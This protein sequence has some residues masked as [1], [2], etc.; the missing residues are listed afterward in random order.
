MSS[1]AKLKY[2]TQEGGDW[3]TIRFHSL[4]MPDGRQWD[5]VN[6]WRKTGRPT[7]PWLAYQVRGLLQE[8]QD[9][10]ARL[11]ALNEYLEDALPKGL[12]RP[13]RRRTNGHTLQA[14]A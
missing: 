1:L 2:T 9:A 10:Q 11:A 7:A 3:K 6:G 13:K 4:E 12:P 14:S 8:I 5:C